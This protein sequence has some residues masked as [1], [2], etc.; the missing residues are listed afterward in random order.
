VKRC[1]VIFALPERQWQWSAE[2]DDAATV[3]DYLDEAR[4]QAGAALVPWD[5][6]VGIFGE[7]CGRDAVP[8]DGDRIEIYRP[9]KADPKESRRARAQ[10]ARAAARGPAASRLRS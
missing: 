8:Q 4:R 1:T 2:L 7:L 6:D 5:G 9:L 3:G 10:R